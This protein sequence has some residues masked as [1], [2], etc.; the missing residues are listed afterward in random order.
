[1][2][3]RI[4]G[5]DAAVV[6]VAHSAYRSLD[7]SALKSVMRLPVLVDGRRVFDLASANAAGFSYS[8]VGIS[9]SL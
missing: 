1:L 3:E 5:C 8:G 2:F 6:M 4:K 9:V 7:L